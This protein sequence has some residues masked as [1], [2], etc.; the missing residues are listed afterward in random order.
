M[1]AKSPEKLCQ[2]W[3]HARL[4]GVLDIKIVL[5][6]VGQCPAG[7]DKHFLILVVQQ[8]CQSRQCL[9]D[10]MEGP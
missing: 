1:Q 3:A 9:A 6:E 2:P 10:L 5:S 4:N 8:P 7:L